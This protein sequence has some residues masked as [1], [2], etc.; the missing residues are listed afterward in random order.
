M[1]WWVSKKK[2][3]GLV[4]GWVGAGGEVPPEVQYANPHDHD[5]PSPVHTGG[6]TPT[7]RGLLLQARKENSE[8]KQQL[9]GRPPA[10]PS[11]H[12]P[13]SFFP[14]ESLKSMKANPV[15]GT[16]FSLFRMSSPSGAHLCPLAGGLA[17]RGTGSWRPS[18]PRP[19]RRAP[20]GPSRR[21]RQTWTRSRSASRLGPHHGSSVRQLGRHIVWGKN[22]NFLFLRFVRFSILAKICFFCSFSMLFFPSPISGF[23]KI[24]R[25]CKIAG[26]GPNSP[27]RPKCLSFFLSFFCIVWST[28]CLF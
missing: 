27:L 5:T 15:W 20:L 7:T 26:F 6:A 12:V 10:G 23:R 21:S 14:R 25:A 13:T 22:A 4:G 2:V 9:F 8:L 1:C 3:A 19:P 16:G 24:F 11:A 28:N 18:G 17:A